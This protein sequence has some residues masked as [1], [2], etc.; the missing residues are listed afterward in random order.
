MIQYKKRVPSLEGLAEKRK[1]RRCQ[2]EK[3]DVQ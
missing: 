3:E 2:P 1:S